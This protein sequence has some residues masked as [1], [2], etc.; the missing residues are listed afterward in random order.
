MG[1][2]GWHEELDGSGWRRS[3]RCWGTASG[4]HRRPAYLQGLLGPGERKSLQPLAAGL[5]LKGHDQLQHFVASPAWDDAPLRRL[6]VTS[7]RTRSSARRTRCWWST[8]PPCRSRAIARSAWRGSTAAPWAAGQLPG[9]GLAYP[10]AGRGSGAARLAAVPPEAWVA[11]PER[12][13]R[14]GVPEEQRCPLAK[15]DLALAELDCVVAAGARFGG[16]VT[17][18]GD[19]ISAGLQ[20]DLNALAWRGLVCAAGLPTIQNVYTTR[21]RCGGRRRRRAQENAPP[22]SEPTST[23]RCNSRLSS[24]Q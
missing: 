1:D 3:W 20:L 15:T 6:L 21:S 13:A 14:A 9:P 18:A 7:G 10:G 24:S 4:A 22:A 11:D 2:A 5:G 23:V 17:D 19:G 16:L 12:C 8:T